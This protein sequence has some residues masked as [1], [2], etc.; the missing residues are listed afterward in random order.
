M[1]VS[2]EV[3]EWDLVLVRHRRLLVEERRVEE[4]PREGHER[5]EKEAACVHQRYGFASR[6]GPIGA[7]AGAIIGAGSAAGAA[8]GAGR[9]RDPLRARRVGDAIVSVVSSAAGVSAISA[10]AQHR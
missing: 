8:I 6:V 5:E 9:R 10:A 3:G 7:G 2:L 4:A 1:I